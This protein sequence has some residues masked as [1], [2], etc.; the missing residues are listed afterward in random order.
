MSIIAPAENRMVLDNIEWNTFL[1][2]S[3]QRRGSVPRITYDRG[4]MRSNNGSTS[5]HIGSLSVFGQD[6]RF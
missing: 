5:M 1:D 6:I 4:L 3:N 2:L